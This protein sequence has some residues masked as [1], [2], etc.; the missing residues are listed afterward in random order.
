LT[1]SIQYKNAEGQGQFALIRFDKK[2]WQSAVAA[3]EAQIRIK[4]ERVEEK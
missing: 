3:V 4:V 2:N 1:A